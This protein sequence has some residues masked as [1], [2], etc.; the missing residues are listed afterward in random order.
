MMLAGKWHQDLEL[1]AQGGTAAG[2]AVFASLR[3]TFQA[4]LLLPAEG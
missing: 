4:F 1:L 3:A 2:Q